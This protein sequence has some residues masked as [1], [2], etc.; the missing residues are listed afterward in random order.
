MDGE[1]VVDLSSKIVAPAYEV[2]Y[3]D[4][5]AFRKELARVGRIEYA[6]PSNYHRAVHTAT[7]EE[8]VRI[9]EE[10]HGEILRLKNVEW[11]HIETFAGHDIGRWRWD[12]WDVVTEFDYYGEPTTEEVG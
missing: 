7:L 2:V 12:D 10:R 3:V 4:L 11:D 5:V 8:A 6:E 9:A 1:M